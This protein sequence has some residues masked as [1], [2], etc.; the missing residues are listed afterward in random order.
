M[1]IKYQIKGGISATDF[2]VMN[3][4]L[5]DF[6]NIFNGSH[7]STSD[8]N[9]SCVDVSSCEFSGSINSNIYHTAA[10]DNS[11]NSDD[12]GHVTFKK[13][14]HYYLTDNSYT[15]ERTA[16]ITLSLNS[17]DVCQFNSANKIGTN[18]LP[19]TS[20]N[21]STWFGSEDIN[22]LN[23]N[24]APCF[25]FFI[26]DYNFFWVLH[27]PS[28]DD[29]SI[30]GLMDYEITNADKYVFDNISTNYCPMYIWAIQENNIYQQIGVVNNTDY[31]QMWFG[32]T[33][34]LNN[35][36]S[37]SSHPGWS[38]TSESILRSYSSN[39]S[40]NYPSLYPK[41]YL[42]MMSAP[43]PNGDSAHQ[44]H[45]LFATGHTNS[46]LTSDPI[47]AKFP[48]IWRT[49]DD[50]G[51]TGQTITFDGVDYVVMIGH[52]SGGTSDADATDNWANAS[53]LF[54][55]TIGGN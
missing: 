30:G 19:Q 12:E 7:T 16:R 40:S 25:Y 35:V 47:M 43:L 52:K 33:D 13:R 2:T 51:Y 29:G 27:D 39:D 8:F 11:A 54:R 37:I 3:S 4:I 41:P 26:S 9:T 6:Q 10:R 14:H 46:D 22:R 31:S 45:P 17:S 44:L 5:A 36:G 28:Q 42:R 1:F 50:I 24:N 18:Q 23:L 15:W 21:G 38:G 55:K 53:Y 49:T 20:T 34:Y 48:Y 32:R